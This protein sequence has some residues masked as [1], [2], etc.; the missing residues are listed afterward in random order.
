MHKYGDIRKVQ[1]ALS[2]SNPSVTAIYAM[3]DELMEDKA[4]ARLRRT[5]DRRSKTS[6]NV[7]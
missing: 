4:A 6:T 2:H 1:R 5:A 3:A 7:N